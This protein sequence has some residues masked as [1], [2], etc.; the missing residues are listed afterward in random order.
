MKSWTQTCD[1]SSVLGQRELCVTAY[2]P[3]FYLDTSHLKNKQGSAGAG[4][5]EEWGLVPHIFLCSDT[6]EISLEGSGELEA[7]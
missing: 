5:E 6:E 2:Q 3:W 4:G 7:W 1:S